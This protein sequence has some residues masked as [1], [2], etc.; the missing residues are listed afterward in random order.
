MFYLIR[1]SH[2]HRIV[3]ALHKDTKQLSVHEE[4][5][6]NENILQITLREYYPLRIDKEFRCFI[7][8]KKLVGISQYES[9][10][11][12]ANLQ[13]QEGEEIVEQICN[14]FRLVSNLIYE[15]NCVVDIAIIE[16]NVY[17]VEIHLWVS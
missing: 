17:I 5:E 6:G 15:N 12:F 11:F 16:E 10:A 8:D 9:G 3:K 7:L 2:S 14:F 1:F 4:N 13:G